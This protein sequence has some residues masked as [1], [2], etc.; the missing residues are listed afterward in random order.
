MT[1]QKL[2]L[3][4]KNLLNLSKKSM[5]NNY[6]TKENYLRI[7]YLPNKLRAKINLIKYKRISIMKYYLNT[8]RNK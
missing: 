7:D 1:N 5:K 6:K 8:K 3:K 4:Q 2:I